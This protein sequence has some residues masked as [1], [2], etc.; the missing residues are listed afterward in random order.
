MTDSKLLALAIRGEIS[1]LP[2]EK[3]E[4]VWHCKNVIDELIREHGSA[5][6][7]AIY[8]VTSELTENK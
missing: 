8:L 4:K 2:D 1:V 3:F 5:A 6:T 7:L